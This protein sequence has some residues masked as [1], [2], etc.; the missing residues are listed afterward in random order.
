MTL[1]STYGERNKIQIT[2][3]K[4]ACLAFSI[5]LGKSLENGAKTGSAQGMMI[6]ASF[7]MTFFIV[8]WQRLVWLGR[9]GLV[10]EY[11]LAVVARAARLLLGLSGQGRVLLLLLVPFSLVSN[12]G[13]I[14]GQH[15]WQN[16]LNVCHQEL[17]LLSHGI[18]SNLRYCKFCNAG[19]IRQI[20][21]G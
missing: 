8:S 10:F 12:L 3:A 9:A 17:H 2:K 4:L 1:I 16:L 13:L 14:L 19:V 18:G 7:R 11:P 5:P 6:I 15:V 20:W 21:A